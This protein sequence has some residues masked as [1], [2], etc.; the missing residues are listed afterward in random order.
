MAKIKELTPFSVLGEGH[1]LPDRSDCGS[2]SISGKCICR[3][4]LGS[5]GKRFPKGKGWGS[6]LLMS[7]TGKNRCIT[8]C[9]VRFCWCERDIHYSFTIYGRH[10]ISYY[11]LAKLTELKKVHKI[12]HFVS[13]ANVQNDPA[14]DSA[15]VKKERFETGRKE[16]SNFAIPFLFY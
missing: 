13:R 15:D 5:A 9:F 12:R 11:N 6:T 10:G 1:M 3:F 16:K 14:F 2:Y 8:Y 7:L 4:P